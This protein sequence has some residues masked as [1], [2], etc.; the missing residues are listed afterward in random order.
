MHIQTKTVTTLIAGWNLFQLGDVEMPVELHN[1]VMHGAGV[2]S[3]QARLSE[4]KM[5]VCLKIVDKESECVC[6]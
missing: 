2:A 3:A 1:A 4:W 6:A 5:L